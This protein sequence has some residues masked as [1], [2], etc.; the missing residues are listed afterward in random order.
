MRFPYTIRK[1]GFKA[2]VYKAADGSF[3]AVWPGPHGR[4]KRQ[5]AKFSVAKHEAEES[6]KKLKMGQDVLLELPKAAARNLAKAVEVLLENGYGDFSAVAAEYVTARKLSQGTSIA[7]AA[8]FW[9]ENSKGIERISFEKAARNWFDTFRSRWSP[10]HEDSTRRRVDTL[11]R[12][13]QVDT[14]DLSAK[15]LKL[16]FDEELG[17]KSAK[18]RNHFRLIL[19]GIV[20]HAV[21]QN[22]LAEKNGLEGILKDEAETPVDTKIITAKQFKALLSAADSELR[23][24]IALMGFCGLRRAEVQRLTWDDV[25]NSEGFVEVKASKAKTGSRRVVPRCPALDAWLAPYRKSKGRLWM[26][27]D[28]VLGHKLTGLKKTADCMG[29]NVLRHSYGSYQLAETE[30]AGRV[31]FWMGN[32]P[33]MVFKH[34]WKL[35]NPVQAK[36]WFSVLPEEV[37]TKKIVKLA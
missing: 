31:A 19:R 13:F 25:W 23:P 30:D 26:H 16:F 12:C 34:Y 33:S 8:R 14:C 35:T 9:A 6:L 5:F 11:C 20:R 22:W 36:E 15:L 17:E 2:K 18:L 10:V 4:V 37:E 27:S 28:S 3:H 1:F 24:V 21:S 29:G 32:S 7:D